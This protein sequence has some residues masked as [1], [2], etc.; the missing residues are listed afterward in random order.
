[1]WMDNT[2]RSRL[3]G[4]DTWCDR[5]RL[6]SGRRDN[7]SMR[8]R[9]GRTYNRRCRKREM[10]FGCSAVY[11]FMQSFARINWSRT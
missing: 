8:D 1:M 5:E 4:H 10:C 9:S 2:W 11:D 3:G 7:G 6:R